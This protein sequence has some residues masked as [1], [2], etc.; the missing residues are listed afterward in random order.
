M[1]PQSRS[2]SPCR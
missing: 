2:A 1:M